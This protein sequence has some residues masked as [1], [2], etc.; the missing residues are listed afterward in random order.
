MANEYDI[1]SIFQSIEE[2]LIASMKRNITRHLNE[3]KE[4]KINWSMWQTEQLKGLQEFRNENKDLFK[5]YWNTIAD[6]IE[7]MFE[8]SYNTGGM[9][10]EHKILDA[11]KKGYKIKGSTDKVSSSFFSVNSRKLKALISATQEDIK[12]AGNTMLRYTNDQYRQIIYEAQVYYNMGAGSL[13]QA[14]DMASQ[15]FLSKGINSIQYK[16]GAMV[17]IS[18]YVEMCLRTSNKRANLEGEVAKREDWGIHTVL[19]PNR[20]VGCPYCVKFQGKVFIDDV[21]GLGTATESKSSGYPLLS[22]AV[23]QGLFHVNCKDTIVTFFEG[24]TEEP[25]PPTEEQQE[26]KIK[27]YNLQQQQRYNERQIRKYK[28]LELGSVD[29]E[30][31]EKYKNKVREWQAKQ[32]TLIDDH[33]S[34]LKRDYNRE[35][36]RTTANVEKMVTNEPKNDIIYNS[37][38]EQQINTLQKASNELYASLNNFDQNVINNYTLGNYL[39][40][41]SYLKGD[42]LVRDSG[43]L[44]FTNE[45]IKA[46]DNAI[47]KYDLQ[48]NVIAYRGTNKQY[49][50]DYKIG[51]EFTEKIY[52]STSL[53]ED[54]AKEFRDHADNPYMVEIHVPKGAKLLYV[55]YNSSFVTLN[56]QELLIARNTKYKVISKDN[57]KIVLEV[58]NGD[59]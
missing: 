49:Y 29:S 23:K 14:I 42:N 18:S 41:N 48:E 37:A 13:N 54:I 57:E 11:I 32:R 24:I 5:G 30:N 28:R 8:K 43:T 19:V 59:K 1:V 47:S 58:I 21:Y 2:T 27:R 33:S 7:E 38:T 4:L 40:I 9:K 39:E 51:D 35:K 56:E 16:N 15:D 25:E 45:K 55:G 10:Q 12:R 3:E 46:I 36:I 26:S 6:N 44:K 52:Y 22:T 50:N 20:A 17:N 34:V 31:T 53:N